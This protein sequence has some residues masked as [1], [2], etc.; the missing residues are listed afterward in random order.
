M[1]KN[2]RFGFLSPLAGDF[3]T[4]LH[5]PPIA[6]RSPVVLSDM[7]ALKRCKLVSKLFGLPSDKPKTQVKKKAFTLI[8]MLVCM[9]LLSMAGSFV[10]YKGWG[11]LQEKRFS[12]SCEKMGS[13][14]HL[15]KG[16]AVSYQIDIELM[17]EQKGNRVYVTRKTEAFPEGIKTLFQ[18][19]IAMPEIAF[20]E[21]DGVKEL[22]FYGNGWIEG[23]EKVTFF[24]PKHTKKIY[25]V[26]IKKV[27]I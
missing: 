5:R 26:M 10:V 8:E 27:A 17:L 14:I 25:S 23:D 1:P 22:H 3:R 15:T 24:M 9:V 19:T 13:E 11:M 12:T 18:T 7:G 16:L 4:I 6:L 21:G 2:L 20:R